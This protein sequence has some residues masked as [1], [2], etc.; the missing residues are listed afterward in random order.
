MAKTCGGSGG[1]AEFFAK[2]HGDGEALC[3]ESG[4]HKVRALAEAGALLTRFLADKESPMANRE[5]THSIQPIVVPGILLGVGLGG[6][7]DGIVFHQLLQWH[8][9]LTSHGDY[10][11]ST[12]PGLE[13]NTT[14]DGIFHTATWVATVAGLAML[15]Y[16]DRRY[17]V[18]WS[19]VVLG[20]LLIGWGGFNVVEG[21]IHH[22]ILGIHHVRDDLGGPLGWDLAF[23]AWG[24]IFF[25]SGWLMVKRGRERLLA[26]EPAQGRQTEL[27][28]RAPRP[29]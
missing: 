21:V 23:L 1:F 5:S 12:V 29:R 24:A 20:A 10:P 16:A 22:H 11:M 14:W 27:G 13:V 8:H 19:P 18:G 2:S 28:R 25:A 7:F 15:W 26:S 9:M 4:T 17:D 3:H 6:F